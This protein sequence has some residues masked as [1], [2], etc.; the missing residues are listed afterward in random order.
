MGKFAAAALTRGHAI[1]ISW[2]AVSSSLE[3]RG[4]A[5]HGIPIW[6]PSSL[7]RSQQRVEQEV[8]TCPPCRTSA[9]QPKQPG[10]SRS[11]LPVCHLSKVS[12]ARAYRSYPSSTWAVPRA[13]PNIG[14]KQRRGWTGAMVEAGGVQWDT[15]TSPE[16][17]S[18]VLGF[19][20]LPDPDWLDLSNEISPGRCISPPPP[21]PP[22]PLGVELAGPLRLYQLATTHAN[23]SRWVTL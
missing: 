19:S 2:R 20:S 15:P 7:L 9:K 23:T 22:M 10:S 4:F 17:C 5:Q 16:G 3:F 13:R 14:Q 6:D 18:I 8:R 12:R 21:S 11:P 1:G